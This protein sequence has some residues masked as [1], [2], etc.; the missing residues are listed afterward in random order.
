MSAAEVRSRSQRAKLIFNVGR[1]HRHLR[2]GHFADRIG[3][4]API[5]LTAV[6]EYLVYEVF[7]CAK[8]YVERDSRRRVTSRHLLFAI[9][10]DGE[11]NKLLP[12]VIISES[13]VVPFIHPKLLPEGTKARREAELAL[14]S[15]DQATQEL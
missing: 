7:D 1:V 8:Y 15:D 10:K 12:N 4:K 5:Y 3:S 2:E 11:L 14:E 6:L 9:R 13:G